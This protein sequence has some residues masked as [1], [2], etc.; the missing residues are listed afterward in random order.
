MTS[1][2]K[3]FT[4]LTCAVIL[5]IHTSKSEGFELG[6]VIQ[7]QCLG[8]RDCIVELKEENYTLTNKIHLRGKMLDRLAVLGKGYGT[9]IRC[10]FNITDEEEKEHNVLF[11]IHH[12]K[13]VY[14]RELHFRNCHPA[15]VVPLK[16]G[17][18]CVNNALTRSRCPKSPHIYHSHSNASKHHNIDSRKFE[19]GNT[20]YNRNYTR[21]EFQH[22]SLNATIWLKNCDNVTIDNCS[23][24]DFSYNAIQISNAK[25]TNISRL[26]L[27]KSSPYSKG[28][29][30]RG[31][32]YEVFKQGNDSAATL[33]IEHSFFE[34]IATFDQNA[35]F[36]M[37]VSASHTLKDI[38]GHYGGAGIKILILSDVRVDIK[39]KHCYFRR[40]TALQGGGLLLATTD[41]ILGYNLTIEDSTFEWNQAFSKTY[42]KPSG[43]AILVKQRTENSQIQIRNTRFNS[44]CANQ[45]GAIGIDIQ[46]KNEN[47]LK[48]TSDNNS[49]HCNNADSGAGGALFV[50]NSISIKNAFHLKKSNFTDNSAQNGGAI[51]AL[52]SY[53]EITDSNLKFNRAKLGGAIALL[54]SKLFFYGFVSIEENVA[55]LKGGGLYLTA[56][57][58]ILVN[59]RSH[60]S[61]KSNQAFYK[62]G[63]IYVFNHY[64]EYNY[65]SWSSHIHR[66]KDLFCFIILYQN[67]AHYSLEFSENTV[68]NLSSMFDPTPSRGSDLF[69]NTWGAC[70]INDKK[71]T[72]IQNNA[73]NIGIQIHKNRDSVGT[74]IFEYRTVDLR[75]ESLCYFNR[76]DPQHT[77]NCKTE[78]IDTKSFPGYLNTMQNEAKKVIESFKTYKR[79]PSYVYVIYPGFETSITI[80]SEDTLF[81]VVLTDTVILFE[82]NDPSL[83]NKV[84]FKFGSTKMVKASK[85]VSPSSMRVNFSL[86]T[87]EDKW[88]H[89]KL[90]LKSQLSQRVVKYCLPVILAR[91]M[92]G[93]EL[94][95]NKCRPVDEVY[96]KPRQGTRVKILKNYMMVVLRDENDNKTDLVNYVKCKWF[97]CKC[98][99]LRDDCTFNILKPSEQCIGGLSG[100][101]CTS[102]ENG[103][104][105]APFYSFYYALT[106]KLSFECPVPWH[107]LTLAFYFVICA[108]ILFVIIIL[109][110]DI[111]EDY[112][113]SIIF[114][115]GIL[116]L[117]T[118]SCEVNGN[119]IFLKAIT[120]PIVILNLKVTHIYPFCFFQTNGL[121]EAFFELYAPLTFVL[122]IAIIYLCLRYCSGTR[123][124]MRLK[125][126]KNDIVR[127]F[128]TIFIL[129]YTNLCGGA[130]LIFNCPRDSYGVRR[131]LI[132][133]EIKCFT[134]EHS[135]VVIAAIFILYILSIVPLFLI[136]I[137][138]TKMNTLL[139]VVWIY[140]KRYKAKYKHWEVMKL[141][142]RFVLAITLVS[143]GSKDID[144][145]I[146][147]SVLCLV[148]MAL[149]SIL[150]PSENKY[151]NHYE[152]F[153]I[154][155]LAFVGI[156]NDIQATLFNFLIL[157]P[158]LI[159]FIIKVYQAIKYALKIRKKMK[160]DAET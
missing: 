19:F 123:I 77:P 10:K 147:V 160:N 39:I 124:M 111:F 67:D 85:I 150:R 15:K 1:Y 35:D 138:C 71:P 114:Y 40:C 103:E 155:C 87:S 127:Q 130:F 41:N 36:Q 60:V 78:L 55:D 31:V 145:C 135:K 99:T 8:K 105:L 100:S 76:S 136:F 65:L 64:E 154:L 79:Q 22:K 116:F 44:N 63:G 49:F 7:S 61:L 109:Q 6:D 3:L 50:E 47:S 126:G 53:V 91:C 140:E 74:D 115:S 97:Q 142:V 104:A 125:L 113:R 151:A 27:Y 132:D 52:N 89:G 152:S 46:A 28:Y 25:T 98:A 45:G 95:S 24:N 37:N 2:I 75:A 88:L 128:W 143:P 86:I 33:N 153:C 72:L 158:Y 57:S 157:T 18:Q 108:I 9:Q 17:H 117:M 4:V 42:L 141:V 144:I 23:F 156:R 122:Y 73:S 70:S 51:F 12:L 26:L 119:D 81:H 121:R 83:Q 30:A 43:G 107:W 129:L 20:E 82:T 96:L 54:S 69:V 112:T 80:V 34:D 149:N 13:E 93:L 133:G 29:Q 148:L 68:K 48:F 5:F 134:G 59:E 21:R 16:N 110:I 58:K 137:S 139:P 92:P 32:L 120:F 11:S 56:Y 94:K 146:I 106:G 101:F 14:L 84:K 118:I 66:L 62:G 90:C 131:W 159:I 38:E 102:S